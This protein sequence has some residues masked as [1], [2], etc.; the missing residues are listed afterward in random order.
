LTVLPIL[1]LYF[2]FRKQIIRGVVRNDLK[3]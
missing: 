3:G 2:I 1:I